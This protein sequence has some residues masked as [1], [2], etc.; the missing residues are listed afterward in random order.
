[1]AAVV[2][3]ADAVE[4]FHVDGMGRADGRLQ[5]GAAGN[6]L[7]H[8]SHLRV[9]DVF[10]RI[11]VN[12]SGAPSRFARD[13]ARPWTGGQWNAMDSIRIVSNPFDCS[14]FLLIGMHTIAMDTNPFIAAGAL[15]VE[16]V[17]TQQ[18]PAFSPSAGRQTLAPGGFAVPP[19]A[20]KRR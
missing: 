6:T 19:W 4:G 18:H 13:G 7:G 10:D 8:G 9:I 2:L 1:M 11:V 5:F 3:A 12:P 17:V 14:A 15:V 16:D 20:G